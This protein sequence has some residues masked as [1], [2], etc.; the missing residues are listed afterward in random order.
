ML[1]QLHLQSW[2]DLTPGFNGLGKDNCKTRRE[3]FKFVRIVASYIEGLTASTLSLNNSSTRGLP[4]PVN[5]TLIAKW[6]LVCQ[7]KISRAG[8]GKFVSLVLPLVSPWLQ[9]VIYIETY[10]VLET[11]ITILYIPNLWFYVQYQKKSCRSYKKHDTSFLVSLSEEMIASL[12]DQP[13]NTCW[14]TSPTLIF[15]FDTPRHKS[16]DR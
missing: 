12:T 7:R 15:S 2:L 5:G 4:R 14:R 1:L 10:H 16:D 6:E 11:I 8:W 9:A 13:H 3:T